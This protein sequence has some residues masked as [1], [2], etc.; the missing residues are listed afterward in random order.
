MNNFTNQIDY[1]NLCSFLNIN[2]Q[3]QKLA[4]KV[5]DGTI[6]QMLT[7]KELLKQSLENKLRSDNQRDI[8]D[9]DSTTNEIW[10]SKLTISQKKLLTR[11]ADNVNKTRNSNTIELI[12]RI[13][14]PQIT[15]SE[16]E[17]LFFNG[18][19]FHD[20]K[21]LESSILPLGVVYR[22]SFDSFQ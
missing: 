19:S 18:T 16:F 1:N 12:A 2:E 3:V 15:N 20:D 17:N 21:S 8:I 13:N 11:F 14:T 5:R 7:K 10:N 9:L 4:N 6:S 22:G